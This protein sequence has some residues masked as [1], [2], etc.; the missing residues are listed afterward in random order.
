[1][2]TPKTIEDL[3]NELLYNIFKL[4]DNR[5][6]YNSSTKLRGVAI[7]IDNQKWKNKLDTVFP[8][9]LIYINKTLE[10]TW[11]SI[12]EDF[13]Q[14]NGSTDWVLWGINCGN[15]PSEYYMNE[16]AAY[17]N[18]EAFEQLFLKIDNPKNYVNQDTAN[19]AAEN[20]HVNVVDF[21]WNNG[22]KANRTRMDEAAKYGHFDIIKY[23]WDKTGKMHKEAANIAAEHGHIRIVQYLESKRIFKISQK[24][25]DNAIING[26]F[27]F[28]KFLWDY[29]N[30]MKPSKNMINHA[31]KK[32]N[33]EMVKY[34]YDKG[35]RFD[36]DAVGT[37][38][39]ED[40]YE[41]VEFAVSVGVL[42]KDV[43]IWDIVRKGR[44]EML[45]ILYGIGFKEK[46]CQNTLIDYISKQ[47]NPEM[48]TFLVDNG[49]NPDVYQINDLIGKF[50]LEVMEVLWNSSNIPK[51]TKKGANKAAGFG[52]IEVVKFLWDKGIEATRS[53]ASKAQERLEYIKQ[54]EN[55]D[56]FEDDKSEDVLKFLSEHGIEPGIKFGGDYSSESSYNE[57][58]EGEHESDDGSIIT[59]RRHR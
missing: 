39:C 42:P 8:G 48:V 35:Y 28:I 13:D 50:S 32:G 23:I 3:P 57:Y 41:L 53:G 25:V 51:P 24:S 34:L 6:L 1:M 30:D 43:Y 17:G 36:V 11:S 9:S 21:L 18:L 59:Y 7:D 27:D 10:K 46:V 26:H 31:M 44:F 22:I 52:N 16:G 2:D 14:G 33:I 19:T 45:K 40:Y 55:L 20:G 29:D 47:C 15:Y 49:L 54:G 38:V 56:L 4:T 37:A 58:S 12:Y 5:E